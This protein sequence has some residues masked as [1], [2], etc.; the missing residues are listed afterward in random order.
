MIGLMKQELEELVVMVG[1]RE[2]EKGGMYSREE[3]GEEG[4]WRVRKDH[5]VMM[6][7]EKENVIDQN[8]HF[9]NQNN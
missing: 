9:N 4:E 2:G 8:N 5:G 6:Y 7:Y 1:R 3:D